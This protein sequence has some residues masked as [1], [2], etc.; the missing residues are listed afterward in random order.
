[1][2]ILAIGQSRFFLANEGKEISNASFEIEDTTTVEYVNC[3]LA[4]F[5]EEDHL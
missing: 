4:G 2:W 1:M 5:W 3:F